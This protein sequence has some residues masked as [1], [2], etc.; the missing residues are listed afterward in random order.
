M[1]DGDKKKRNLNYQQSKF[2]AHR[3]GWRHPPS[4]LAPSGWVCS[5]PT[6]WDGDMIL[7]EIKDLN[8]TGSEP[9]VWDGD[10]ILKEIKDLNI[11]GSEPTVWDGD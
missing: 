7:K 11:T 8:I 6:V 10:M 9:T 3:V 1:W 2:R 4:G 5:E